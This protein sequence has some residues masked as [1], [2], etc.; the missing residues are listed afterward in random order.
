MKYLRSRL[1]WA[2]VAGALLLL[3]G[4]S[5]TV[6]AQGQS[7]D[8]TLSSLTLSDIDFGTFASGTS[9]YT[10]SVA[11]T[12][13]ET[14]VT[15]TTSHSGASYVIKLGGV[16]DDAGGNPARSGQQRHHRRGSRLR[17]GKTTQTYTV[18]VT[19]PASTDATL[20]GVSLTGVDFGAFASGTTSY[21][22]NA[23]NRVQETTVTPTVK[24]LRGGATSSSSTVLKTR[25][26][27][28]RSA[29]AATSHHSGGNRRRREHH[30][31]L[32]RDGDPC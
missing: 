16:T 11:D 6:L 13:T 28:L 18:T 24:P 5:P 3:L 1:A 7:T 9:S 26:A 30:P 15:P 20:S 22:G 17:T 4:L 21:T 25:T 31:D 8:A 14:T 27:P 10:A 2:A 32:H 12:V 23:A 29:W 19:R